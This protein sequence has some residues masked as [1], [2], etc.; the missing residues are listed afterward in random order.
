MGN[1]TNISAMK[2][3]ADTAVQFESLAPSLAGPSQAVRFGP[4]RPSPINASN[5][6]VSMAEGSP[7]WA[8]SKVRLYSKNVP[9][10]EGFTD[11][12]IHGTRDGKAFSVIHNGVECTLGHRQIAGWLQSQ[13]VKGNIRLVSCYSGALPKGSVA[14]HLANKLGVTVRAPTNAITIHPSG[15]LTA[16]TGTKWRSLFPGGE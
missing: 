15:M 3:M 16:P 12:F 7:S 14:Q 11:V 6:G 1:G 10:I 4:T 2:T 8:G 5:K 13:G 9:K